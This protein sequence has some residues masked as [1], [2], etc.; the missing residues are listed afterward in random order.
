VA[1]QVRFVV[2]DEFAGVVVLPP[3]RQLRHVRHHP[4]AASSPPLARATHPWCIA[5]LRRCR[6]E[7]RASGE[8]SS[9]MRMESRTAGGGLGD[10]EVVCDCRWR[11][12]MDVQGWNRAAAFVE[13]LRICT[14]SEPVADRTTDAVDP[15]AGPP[16]CRAV[17]RHA[18]PRAS[19]IR[20]R[21]PS[22][23]CG[24]QPPGARIGSGSGGW[25]GR[26]PVATA[27]RGG[28]RQRGTRRGTPLAGRP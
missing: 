27:R 23:R 2:C 19:L 8:A 12:G 28:T 26:G 5:V 16:S 18:Q 20:M 6:V 21:G 25:A 3:Y 13:R 17:P 22:W 14:R 4:A 11:T 24:C 7:R 15:V 9:V 1:G 10:G